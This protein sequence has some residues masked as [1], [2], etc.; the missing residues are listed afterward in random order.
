MSAHDSPSPVRASAPPA[1]VGPADER[2]ATPG[3]REVR[4]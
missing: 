2:A 3:A 4:S 1:L